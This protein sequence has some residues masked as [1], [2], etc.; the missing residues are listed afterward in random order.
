ML[1]EIMKVDVQWK[2]NKTS[3]F[4]PDKTNDAPYPRY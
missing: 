1:H 2:P 3:T 4:K